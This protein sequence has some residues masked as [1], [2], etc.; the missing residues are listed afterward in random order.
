MK[1]NIRDS[2]YSLDE[3]DKSMTLKRLVILGAGGLGQTVRDLACQSGKF[4]S[5]SFLDDGSLLIGVI[6]KCKDFSKFLNLHTEFLVAFGNNDLRRQWFELLAASKAKFATIIHSSAYISPTASIAEGCMILP[7]AIV[8]TNC[9]LN[10]GCIVNIG[11]LV[12]HG[13]ILEEFVHIAPGGIIKAENR[14]PSLLKIESGLVI[15]N[16]QYPL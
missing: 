16:R 10:R 12:D 14:I 9:V 1:L 13:C 4:D 11:A 7:N 5:V 8:N 2:I 3:T 15:Q 6:G